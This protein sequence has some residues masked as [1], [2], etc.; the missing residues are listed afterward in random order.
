MKTIIPLALASLV[1]ALPMVARAE[2]ALPEDLMTYV[3]R[4][5]PE[6]RWKLAEEQVIGGCDVFQVHLTSQVWQGIPWEHDLVVFVPKG[7][8]TKTVVLLNEGG[9][10][11][12]KNAVF[13][14]LVA[15]KVKAPVAI[16]LGIP[17]QPLFDGKR[18]DDLIAE[19]FVRYL[20]TGDGS[21]PLLFPMVKSLVKGMDAIQELSGQKWPEKTENFIVGGASKRGWTTWLTAAADPRVMAIT[22]MVID[23]LNMKA[24][25][26][27]QI[28][29]FGEPS[30]QIDP[31][32]KRG[33]VPLPETA[34]AQKLWAMVDPWIYRRKFTMPKLVV[35][36]NNDRYWTTDALNLYWDDLPGDKYIS[37]TPN[38]GHDLT[39]RTPDGKKLTPF[40]ALNNVGAFVRHL[41]T[42][43]PLPK[44][45]WK[46]DDAPD[47]QLRL[48]VTAE[49]R[50]REA[51]VWVA[52]GPN[53]DLREARWEARPVAVP[54]EGPI[55]ITLPR[56]TEGH[57]AFF[58]DLGY[59]IEDLP[60]WLSTQLRIAGAKSTASR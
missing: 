56:P 27:Y 51:Q 15:G 7:A 18:E 5:E 12:P 35:L 55:V 60:Q 4:P 1:V 43:T 37:Y 24:Q 17:R 41:L 36:G 59:Q 38:A 29:S 11:D 16:L 10:A 13:G 47:G 21:W 33:L 20:E 9:K 8:S 2:T 3:A 40:R 58:A 25:L 32:T 45:D 39:E 30:E 26:P 6:S 42:G 50:P 53:R 52:S 19:T 49:P 46:H 34:A 22:P 14:T 57:T 48:T 28:E 23:T 44:L 54:S 31:Y